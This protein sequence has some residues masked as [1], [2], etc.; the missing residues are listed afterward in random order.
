[1]SGFVRTRVSACERAMGTDCYVTAMSS[2]RI[3]AH[4][5]SVVNGVRLVRPKIAHAA[6]VDAAHALGEQLH[7]ADYHYSWLLVG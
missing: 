6:E 2:V 4:V 7:S 3:P 1:M 5:P